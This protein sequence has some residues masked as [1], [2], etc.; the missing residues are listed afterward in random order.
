MKRI[1]VTILLLTLTIMLIGCA[2]KNVLIDNQKTYSDGLLLS[3]LGLQ[4]KKRITGEDTLAT[5]YANKNF[6]D[7]TVI[8]CIL[9]DDSELPQ[10]EVVVLFHHKKIRNC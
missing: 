3:R 2:K 4:T 5:F 9:V 8:D 6:N 10:L 7:C 1:L